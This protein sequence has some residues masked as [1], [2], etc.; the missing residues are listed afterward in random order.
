MMTDSELLT[1]ARDTAVA[2]GELAA[3][4][5]IDGVQIAASKSSPED[6][7]TAADR[8]TE[9]LIRSLIA[10]ARPDDG[11]LG[12]EDGLVAGTSGLTWIVDPIDGTVNYLYGRPHWAVS[13][14][15]VEGDPDPLTW[16]AIAGA[17]VNPSTGDVFTA[18][19]GSGSFL[20]GRRLRVR[21]AELNLALVATGFSYAAETRRRQGLVVADLLTHVRDIRRAGTASLDLCDVAAQRVDAYFERGLRPWDHAAGALIAAE[22]GATVHGAGGSAA[23]ERFLLAAPPALA[24]DLGRVL[25]DTARPD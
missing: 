4:R 6:V 21:E 1:L 3:R 13:I 18:S 17:V 23:D 5:R 16:S 2:A 20:G 19:R 8:E 15:V 10:G 11:V 22:A 9:R 25:G 7:V 24:R 12:E 14:A